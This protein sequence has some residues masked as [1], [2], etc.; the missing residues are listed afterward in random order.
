MKWN[1]E[2]WIA[3]RI[4]SNFLGNL[5][6]TR[7]CALCVLGRVLHVNFVSISL[8]I[9]GFGFEFELVDTF[10]KWEE[11]E[12]LRKKSFAFF[13]FFEIDFVLFKTKDWEKCR[14]VVVSVSIR[15]LW[16][17]LY[18]TEKKITIRQIVYSFIRVLNQWNRK[19]ASNDSNNT[20]VEYWSWMKCERANDVNLRA[21]VANQLLNINAV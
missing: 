14:I 11:R 4:G 12:F 10:R 18:Y 3:L 17:N 13:L 1:A 5:C 16:M 20:T 7:M 8:S 6:I 19:Y 2:I 21:S 15:F 9:C